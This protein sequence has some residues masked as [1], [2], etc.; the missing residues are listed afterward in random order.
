[1]HTLTCKVNTKAPT[2]SFCLVGAYLHLI[3]F[4]TY[5]LYRYTK[6][7]LE[8]MGAW[9]PE[10]LHVDPPQ[11]VALGNVC[12]NLPKILRVV[13]S[14]RIWRIEGRRKRRKKGEKWSMITKEKA[15]KQEENQQIWSEKSPE[16][17]IANRKRTL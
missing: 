1:M 5:S 3:S 14:H 9:A 4:Y 11:P 6:F 7:L 10:E 13:R 2:S 8:S 17:K 12:L 15:S 16:N